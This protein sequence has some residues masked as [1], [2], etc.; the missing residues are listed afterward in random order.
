[1]K[2]GSDQSINTEL[3]YLGIDGGGSKC[4]ARIVDAAHN[5]LGVGIAGPA[6]PLHGVER[7]IDS[8]INATAFALEDA[9]LAQSYQNQLVAGVGLAGVNLPS[10]Y[11]IMSQWEH[12]FGKM[13]LTTDLHIACLGAHRGAEGAVMVAGTGS[14]GYLYQKGKSKIIG[15]HG[16]PFGDKGS[17]A[18]MGLEAVRAV[19]LAHD[20]LGE[21]TQLSSL[22]REALDAEGLYVVEKMAGARPCH[23]AKLAPLVLQ[24]ADDGDQ[25]A[26]GIVKEGAEY[27]SNVGDKLLAESPAR[28]SLLGGL[29]E[30]LIPWL[31]KDF[32][33]AIAKPLDQPEAGAIFFAE[34]E[35]KFWSRAL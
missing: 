5:I 24:A 11:K 8:M 19:L 9:G 12:P 33:Q 30:R 6:N 22:L 4:K 7:T 10:F 2:T 3:L 23:Y 13:F 21:A 25:V 32:A 14:C 17:G 20:E 26:I 15:A 27:L 35:L 18:W 29:S 34:Q 1:M 31:R 16:F 28:L